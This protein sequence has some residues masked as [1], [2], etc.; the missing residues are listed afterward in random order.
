[1]GGSPFDNL[2]VVSSALNS[3]YGTATSAAD[4]VKKSQAQNY[5]S[6]R[7]QYEA[8]EVNKAK[9]DGSASTGFINWMLTSGWFSLHW[10]AFDWFLRPSAAYFG[11]KK[12]GEPLHISWDYGFL[13]HVNVTNDLYQ[14][15]T[16]LVATADVL[17][18]DLTNKYHNS[19]T[20]TAGPASS[21]VAFTIP[22]LTGL[23]TTY[24]VKLKLQDSTGKTISDNFYWYSTTLDAIGNSCKWYFCAT[25]KFANLTA[26][27]TLPLVTITHSDSFGTATLTSTLTNSSASLGLLIHARVT[28][29]GNDVLP[30]F[31][32]DNYITLLP[33]ESRALTANFPAGTLPPG[34]IVQ[35]DGFNINSN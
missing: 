33:G 23:T 8:Y 15:F 14:T 19:V 24:F 30:V 25:K 21:N 26:L 29:G 6:W 13:N 11:I 34:A 1:M 17:N 28:S 31:W 18:F 27:Q 9:T 32:S 10:Q 12:S 35:L 4:Y 22:G 20:L 16:G 2:N 7:A 3:R 5:E